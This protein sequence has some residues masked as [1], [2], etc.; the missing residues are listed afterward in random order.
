MLCCDLWKTRSDTTE[1]LV[2]LLP[3][4]ENCL[5]L[6]L[7]VSKITTRVPNA[8]FAFVT[9]V[10]VCASCFIRVVLIR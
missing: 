7:A 9:V 3:E 4:L 8:E 1:D 5:A 6:T 2:A 10:C